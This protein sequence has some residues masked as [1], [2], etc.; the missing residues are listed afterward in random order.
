MKNT[1]RNVFHSSKFVAGFVIFMFL[2]V[3]IIVYP[4]KLL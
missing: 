4:I 2:L 3:M 1:L